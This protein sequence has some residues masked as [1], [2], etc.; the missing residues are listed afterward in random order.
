[1]KAFILTLLLIYG[2]VAHATEITCESVSGA[3]YASVLTATFN[4]SEPSLTEVVEVYDKIS[5]IPYQEPTLGSTQKYIKM[6]NS[7]VCGVSLNFATDCYASEKMT[8][9]K[10]L[11]FEY[12]FIFNCPKKKISGSF[13]VNGP[14]ATLSCSNS[15]V[16]HHYEG[17]KNPVLQ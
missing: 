7:S 2:G 13:N 5:N 11:Q 12:S 17:C 15:T 3:V 16:P 8:Q 6:T 9:T 14:Y 10:Y 4:S 1:M